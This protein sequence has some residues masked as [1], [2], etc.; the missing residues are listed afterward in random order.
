[1]KAIRYYQAP[2]YGT[3]GYEKVVEG[4]YRTE[5]RYVTSLSLQIEPDFGEG[6]SANHLAQYPL[7]IIL[8][9]YNIYISDFYSELNTLRSL[10][11]Y[12]EFSAVILEDI[13]GLLKLINH[14]VIYQTFAV[15]GEGFFELVIEE[16]GES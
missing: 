8:D 16:E 3:V 6:K 12:L 15:N 4:V 11:V 1:M 5:G 13:Q 7:E 2:K 9:D 10:R 14:R